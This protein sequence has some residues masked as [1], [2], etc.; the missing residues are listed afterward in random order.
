MDPATIAASVVAL[1][2]PYLKKATEEFAGE[3]GKFAGEA[4]KGA[5][6]F[7]QEKAKALCER[8]RSKFASD[9]PAVE[10]FNRFASDPDAHKG[11]METQLASKL[12]DDKPLQDELAAALAEVKRAAPQIRVVQKMKE[13]E[14]VVGLRAK[15]MTR[16]TAE[17]TQE[18]EKAKNTTG[19]EF[20]E[21]S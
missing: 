12:I 16:G 1:L 21:I 17:V 7:V 8:L 5:A 19:I 4:G 20:D 18:I 2:V 6:L 11:E 10:T 13:A 15:R 9:T 14:A 3:A